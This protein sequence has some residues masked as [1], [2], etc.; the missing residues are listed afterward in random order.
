M[1]THVERTTV[2]RAHSTEV[3]NGERFAFGKNWSRFLR[4]LDE[5]RIAQAERSLRDMLGVADLAGRSFLDVGAG[6]GL[7]SLAARRL[8]A[9]VHSIDYDSASVAC[10]RELRR[11]FFPD[12]PAWTIEQGS[13]LDKAYLAKLGE[14]DVVYSWGVLH[15]TGAMWEAC[16][17]VVP[18]VAPGGMLFISIY[19]DQGAHSVRWRNVKRLYCSG[20]LGR[21][22]V[23]AAYIPAFYLRDALSDVLRGRNPVRRYHDY[24]QN[25][26][27]SV[28]H[29][30]IDWLGG[31]PFEVAKPEEVFDFFRDRG[32][33]LRR[34]T[35]CGGSLGC[36]E[37][38]FARRPSPPRAEAARAEPARAGRT[39][40]PQ[41]D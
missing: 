18:L 27:M 14:H 25:R 35:T 12:D 5:E 22:A 9:R 30:W 8:G 29:D 2:E 13:V 20:L 16:A 31:Y 19:N 33:E 21:S 28:L 26:G 38:V 24:K 32:F 4:V 11:R 17:N 15:H 34:L 7:F 23:C 6:S 10:A 37:F 36:N 41:G 3:K 40:E 39:G 1:T